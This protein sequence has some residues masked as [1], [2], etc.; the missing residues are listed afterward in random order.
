MTNDPLIMKLLA[1]ARYDIRENG[2]IWTTVTGAK[3]SKKGEWRRCSCRLITGYL[4]IYYKYK[5]LALHRILYAKFKGPLDPNKIVNH[6]DYNR[7]N[8]AL[9]NIEL[10][11][12]SGNGLHA[13]QKHDVVVRASFKLNFEKAQMIRKEYKAGIT[14]KELAIKYEVS[15]SS[16]SSVLNDKTWTKHLE[17]A[18]KLHKKTHCNSPDHQPSWVDLNALSE[19]QYNKPTGYSVDHIIPLNNPHVCGLH[20]P[21]NLQYL[22]KKDNEIKSNSFDFTRDNRSWINLKNK[23]K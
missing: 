18:K 7:K 5:Q 1:D 22:S 12:E 15:K 3:G 6:K 13:Y 8:N 17:V 19:I 11:T 2:E 10:I 9:D 21:W 23:K 14:L 20:V 4:F 16:I